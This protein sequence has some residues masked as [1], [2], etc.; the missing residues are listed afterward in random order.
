MAAAQAA[1]GPHSTTTTRAGPPLSLAPI[2]QSLV[3]AGL[4]QRRRR[5]SALTSQASSPSDQWSRQYGRIARADAAAALP[6][7]VCH[8]RDQPSTPRL[9]VAVA[10]YPSRPATPLGQS[11]AAR[12]T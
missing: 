11:G 10:V 12:R 7:R 5:G 3:K 8:A 4:A 2:L 6:H 9:P 1:A